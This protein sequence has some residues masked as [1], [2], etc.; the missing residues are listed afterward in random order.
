MGLSRKQNPSDFS[1]ADLNPIENVLL[2][3]IRKEGEIFLDNLVDL[4][5][6][7]Y[8]DALNAISRMEIKGLIQRAGGMICLT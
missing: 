8:T 5:G 2:S 1:D 6:L 4:S 3:I 7:D